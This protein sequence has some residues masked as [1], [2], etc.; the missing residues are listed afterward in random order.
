MSKIACLGWGSLIW[1]AG[2]LPVA[3]WRED[4]PSLP[5]E[6]ARRSKNGRVT[7]V[8]APGAAEVTVLW[9]RLDVG[10]L[11]EAITLLAKREGCPPHRI[12]HWPGPASVGSNAIG[13]WAEERGLS[14]IVWTAL[15][16]NWNQTAGRVPTLAE[17]VGYLR[18][19]EGDTAAAAEHYIRSA[20]PQIQ[21][22]LRPNL[23][24]A[25]SD[26]SKGPS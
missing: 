5:I 7:L 24:A 10:D 13:A 23:E 18:T 22:G 8:I 19:L 20:P 3:E 14:G 9:T 25:L 26:L 2:E 11:E 4:G 16:A 15:P 12:G 6:F 21:T 17:L 1:N